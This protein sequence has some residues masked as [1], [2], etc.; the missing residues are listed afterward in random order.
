[1]TA[2][3][4]QDTLSLIDW[5]YSTHGNV[6]LNAQTGEASCSGDVILRGGEA[7]LWVQWDH[8]DGNFY[9]GQTSL[10][11]LVGSPHTVSGSFSCQRSGITSLEGAP[12]QVGDRFNCS[13]THITSLKGGPRIVGV[14]FRCEKN[15]LT[16]LEGLPERVGGGIF[17]DYKPTLPLLRLLL[18]QG[19]VQII[20]GN[21]AD[22]IH[23]MN[24]YKG[25]GWKGMVPCARELIK[26]GFKENARL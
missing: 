18:V 8:V 24:K 13:G 5:H 10:T 19:V 26:A 6:T 16:S 3:Q 2:P 15:R 25:T 4:P 1:M 20:L 9:C 22:V 17:L 23:I 12:H 11:S 21:N 7:K 14:N